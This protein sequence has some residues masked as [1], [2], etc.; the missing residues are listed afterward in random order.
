MG[1]NKKSSYVLVFATDTYGQVRKLRLPGFAVHLILVA[2]LIGV[3]SV[4]VGVTSYAHML[5]KVTDYEQVREQRT[6]LVEVNRALRVDITQSRE[7][8]DSL[9][10]LANEVAVSLGLLRLRESPFGGAQM[11]SLPSTP[12][13]QYRDSV[14]RFRF[15]RHHATAVKLYASGVPLG[16]NQD[17]ERLRYTPS[18]WP[19]RGRLVSGF[20]QRIDPFNGEGAF[21]KGVDID[22]DY[23]DSVRV[24][25]DGFVIWAGP[26]SGFGRLVI[27]DH[28]GGITTYY[29]H[30]SRL[31]A[32][33]GQAIERG[34]II[35][36]VG[37]TG[38]AKGPHLHYEVRLNRS[39]L[40]P[41]RFL[42]TGTVQTARN[43]TRSFSAG[44]SD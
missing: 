34:D 7:K 19:I 28:G 5:A 4:L 1:R 43:R 22:G 11:A 2:A 17:I 38:R 6:K 29:A 26:R 10:S 31:R 24:A 44:S 13:T 32:Y 42:R 36:L 12:E 35:G 20:G 18:L 3:G 8:L 39:P 16:P 27:V 30:M 33:S 25:A 9:E 37:S 23:G 15:L 41:W 21:H 14:A 40:N